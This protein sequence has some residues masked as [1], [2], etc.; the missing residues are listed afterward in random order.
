MLDLNIPPPSGAVVL[1]EMRRL[2]DLDD[3][4]VVVVT[5]AHLDAAQHALL[6]T[7][8][9]VL[10]KARFSAELLP[11]AAADAARLVERSA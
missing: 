10:D 9:V 4:P 2:P 6:A 7:S 3:V 1:D 11:H 8:A 5:S